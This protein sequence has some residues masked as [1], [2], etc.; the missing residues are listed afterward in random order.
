MSHDLR[1]PDAQRME[2]DRAELADRIGHAL[3]EDGVIEPLDGLKLRRASV[4]TETGHGVSA[5]SF[6][7]IAQGTKDVWLGDRCYRYDPARYLIA[8]AALPVATRITE[9][10]TERPF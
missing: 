2:A 3:R 8:T 10:S 5:P 7:V 1:Q 4:P 6:C 9:A